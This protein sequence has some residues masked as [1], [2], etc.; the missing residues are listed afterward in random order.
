MCRVIY[1]GFSECS[2]RD[3]EDTPA[4]FKCPSFYHSPTQECPD[5]PCYIIRGE[6]VDGMVRILCGTCQDLRSK[7]YRSIGY[8]DPEGENSAT[9]K[10]W[11][12]IGLRWKEGE[13]RD[14]SPA[15]FDLATNVVWHEL[16]KEMMRWILA[17]PDHDKQLMMVRWT[18][19]FN[20]FKAWLE[21]ALQRHYRDV[22]V[23]D[24]TQKRL[25]QY[26]VGWIMKRMMV[27]RP[28]EKPNKSRL[29]D[30]LDPETFHRGLEDAF[31]NSD[32]LWRTK[33]GELYYLPDA[34]DEAEK[35]AEAE[36][37][38]LWEKQLEEEART[39]TA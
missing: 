23:M 31:Q 11:G 17:G 26:L 37:D 36:F 16:R 33:H 22:E 38:A 21:D 15:L 6:I 39:P 35:E 12:K 24:E 5:G 20:T 13:E 19:L 34:E 3:P 10:L 2:H 7:L 8:Q 32:Y 4:T 28:P 18:E 14:Q 29:F 30:D 1:T 9:W 27:E 25:L